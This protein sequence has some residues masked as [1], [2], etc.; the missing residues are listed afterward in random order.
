[1]ANIKWSS[2]GACMNNLNYSHN[3]TK[4]VMEV[5]RHPVRFSLLGIIFVTALLLIPI[6]VNQASALHL[7][8]ELKW[9]LVFISGNPGCSSHNYQ[10]MYTHDEMTQKYLDL[11]EVAISKYEPECFS[12][13]KYFDEYTN[14]TALA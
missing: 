11:Y 8:D 4:G 14:P 3:I 7:S 1:M 13:L 2:N 6:G 9:Q 10:F 5:R 12:H